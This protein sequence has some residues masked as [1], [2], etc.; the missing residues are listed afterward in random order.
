MDYIV[1]VKSTIQVSNESWER[2]LIVGTFHKENS[3]E[4][5][6]NWAESKKGDL[7]TIKIHKNEQNR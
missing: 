7:S 6:F 1:S 5:I 2:V 3:I 4:D